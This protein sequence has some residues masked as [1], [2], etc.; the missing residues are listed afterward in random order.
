M[1]QQGT[2]DQERLDEIIRTAALIIHRKGYDATSMNDIADAVNLTKAG[3]YYYT[4]GKQDLLFRI[5]RWAMD[6]VETEILQPG[7]Q[8]ADPGERLQEIVRRHLESML[9]DGGVVAILTVEVDKLNSEQKAEIKQRH[10][11]YLYLVRET[12]EEL[13]DQGRLRPN[14]PT[15]GALNMFA[16]IM[17]VARWYQP[18]GHLSRDAV[19]AEITDFVLGGLLKDHQSS[20]RPPEMPVENGG[21]PGA[22]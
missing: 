10:R 22:C 9:V 1:S 6:R 19:I 17:G 4:R 7:R 12:L 13:R 8:I 15:I 11:R 16:T 2:S 21:R 3:L 5:I 20:G 18:G 14:D